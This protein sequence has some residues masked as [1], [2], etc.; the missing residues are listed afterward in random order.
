MPPVCLLMGNSALSLTLG[1]L[2]GIGNEIK[3]INF[4]VGKVLGKAVGNKK[5]EVSQSNERD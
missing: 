4:P 1:L 5:R 2:Q 3:T